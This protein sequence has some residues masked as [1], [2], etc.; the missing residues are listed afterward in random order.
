MRRIICIAATVILASGCA[1]PAAERPGAAWVPSCNTLG[2]TEQIGMGDLPTG[3]E[4]TFTQCRDQGRHT[5]RYEKVDGGWKMVSLRQ[6]T[7]DNCD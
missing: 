3:A 5:F 7:D 1:T 6:T 4:L 2:C